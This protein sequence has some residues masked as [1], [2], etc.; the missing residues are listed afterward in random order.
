MGRN[1][2]ALFQLPHLVMRSLSAPSLALAKTKG[3]CL[4]FSIF[5]AV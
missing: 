4:L 3:I 2:H 5:L 1:G